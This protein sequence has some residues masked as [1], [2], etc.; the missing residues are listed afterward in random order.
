M[1]W[2]VGNDHTM[3]EKKKHVREIARL[4]CNQHICINHHFAFLLEGDLRKITFKIPPILW[5]KNDG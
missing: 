2:S 1:I 4:R 5:I 3:R